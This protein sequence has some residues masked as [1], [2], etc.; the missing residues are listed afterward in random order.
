MVARALAG[1]T[2]VVM[3][4]AAAPAGASPGDRVAPPDLANGCFALASS[5]GRFVGTSGDGY[6]ANVDRTNATPLYL[7]PSGLRTYLIQDSGHKLLAAGTG[8]AV[9]RADGPGPAAEW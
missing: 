1:L 2:A 8:G 3:G 6:V 4:M 9:Q 5:G 7:K